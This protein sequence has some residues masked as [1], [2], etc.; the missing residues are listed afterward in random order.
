MKMT[1]H[2]SFIKLFFCFIK[3]CWPSHGRRWRPPS[4]RDE[5]WSSCSAG[6]SSGSGLWFLICRM[7]RF[8]FLV[9]RLAQLSISSLFAVLA[10][11][12]W[13]LS[14][15]LSRRDVWVSLCRLPECLPH[16]SVAR[17]S[18]SSLVGCLE[19]LVPQWSAVWVFNSS[20]VGFVWVLVPQWLALSECLVPHWSDVWAVWFLIGRL[21]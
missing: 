15:W 2:I 18:A 1:L 8:W 11:F 4:E 19:C 10:E 21:S 17:M 9:G 6:R 12:I 3:A 5:R 13:I 14:G 16:W 7:S 20:V